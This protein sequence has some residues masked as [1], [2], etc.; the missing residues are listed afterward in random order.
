MSHEEAAWD[1]VA[2]GEGI[3]EDLAE[4]L[5]ALSYKVRKDLGRTI[6]ERFVD[7]NPGRKN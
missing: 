3:L 5:R 4:L 1:L 6:P 2:R 7:W